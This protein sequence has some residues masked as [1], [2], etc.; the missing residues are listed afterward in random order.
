MNLLWASLTHKVC[1]ILSVPAGLKVGM[2]EERSDVH[3]IPLDE[4]GFL[5]V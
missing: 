1:S 2:D 5:P 3:V 4:K